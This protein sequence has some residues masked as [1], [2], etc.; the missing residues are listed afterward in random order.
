MDAGIERF[1]VSNFNGY[2]MKNEKPVGDQIHEFQE[3]LRGVE[4]KGTTFSEEFKVVEEKHRSNVEI[5]SEKTAKVNLV[6]NEKRDSSNNRNKYPAK[7]KI[8]KN[9][10]KGKYHRQN[11][12]NQVHDND[13]NH[14]G[15]GTAK[16]SCFVCGRSNHVAKNCYYKK[17]NEYKPRYHNGQDKK[18]S[19][20]GLLLSNLGS[21]SLGWHD[22]AAQFYFLTAAILVTGINTLLTA[23]FS[24]Y[25]GSLFSCR[26][27]LIGV[28]ANCY[29]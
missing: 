3:L 19:N 6:E 16:R 12:H 1:T 14:K 23:V 5:G 13:N 10:N 17:T 8:F 18:V 7:G 15:Q 11:H 2:K 25:V 20:L 22:W 26:I 21:Y 29:L 28:T 9:N 4:K 27:V 24:A